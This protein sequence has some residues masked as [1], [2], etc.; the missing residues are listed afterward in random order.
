MGTV[1]WAAWGGG[2]GVG[3]AP[4]ALIVKVFA[5]LSVLTVTV[6]TAA[7]LGATVMVKGIWALAPGAS[8]QG[9]GDVS[10]A[11]VQPQEG[12]TARTVTTPAE[13]LVRLNVK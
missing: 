2:A 6:L 10:C 9:S 7:E 1:R 12:V 11:T 3:G 8:F 13:T 5:P 4:V